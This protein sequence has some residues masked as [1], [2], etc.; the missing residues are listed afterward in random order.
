VATSAAGVKD[1]GDRASALADAGADVVVTEQGTVG[2]TLTRLA[3]RQVRSI[4]IEGGPRLHRA[5]WEAR[6]VDRVAVFVTPRV[7]GDG[8]V[9]WSLPPRCSLSGLVAPSV[10]PLGPDVLIEGDVHWTD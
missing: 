4:L 6:V 10:V 7:L 2:E 5:F 3:E 1:A 8:A 9:P